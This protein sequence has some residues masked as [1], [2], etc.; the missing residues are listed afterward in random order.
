MKK[1]NFI[2]IFIVL[3]L[4]FSCLKNNE[5]K[6]IFFDENQKEYLNNIISN[7]NFNIEIIDN[8]NYWTIKNI[9]EQELLEIIKIVN[10]KMKIMNENIQNVNTTKTSDGIPYIRKYV[11]ITRENGLEILEDIE[12]EPRLIYDPTHPDSI[13]VGERQGYVIYPNIDLTMEMLDLV[14]ITKIY[15]M[16]SEILKNKYNYI[17]F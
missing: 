12:S 2:G 5:V 14:R 17:I 9:S 1:I 15:E 7:I 6:I 16:F 11:K 10:F 4:F 3:F 8:D 13:K